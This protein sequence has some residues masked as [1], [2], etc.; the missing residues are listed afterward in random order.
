M[1]LASSKRALE[2]D[3]HRD[4]L[5]LVGGMQ[6]RPH[7]GRIGA[8]AI[9]GHLDRQDLRVQRRLFDQVDDALKTL[10]GM[11]QQ[12]VLLTHHLE[13][14]GAGGQRLGQHGLKRTV[15]QAG[16]GVAGKKRLE[17][18]EID[19]T[20]QPVQVNLREPEGFQQ[21]T[22]GFRRGVRLHLEPHGVAAVEA[23]QFFLDRVK[24]IFG[25][26]LIDVEVGVAR[27][28][29]GVRLTHLQPDEEP[30]QVVLDEVLQ[31]EI[32]QPRPQ[33][34]RGVVRDE[35]QPRQHARNLDD[36]REGF[37]FARMV[38]PDDEI[39]GSC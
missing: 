27:H 30:A 32:V 37:A 25:F 29:E 13:D 1:L 10:V 33:T 12:H 7:D 22:L 39:V 11:V 31:R 5:A 20:L 21:K 18:Q 23:A 34:L 24:K 36:G 9:Q 8:G 19:R 35:Q 38:E 16:K 4:L 2:F 15:A 3:Q 14:V 28:A 6:Q 26:L 17:V